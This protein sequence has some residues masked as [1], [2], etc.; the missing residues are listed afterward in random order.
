VYGGGL[1]KVS[2]MALVLSIL[3]WVGCSFLASL[4]GFFLARS[5]MRG[6]REGRLDPSG[7]GQSQVAFWLSAINLC[8]TVLGCGAY[9]LVVVFMGVVLGTAAREVHWQAE[10]QAAMRAEIEAKAYEAIV[11][12]IET[13][14]AGKGAPERAKWKEVR[15]QWDAQRKVKAAGMLANTAATGELLELVTA[16]MRLWT[17]I[18]EGEK[19]VAR[20]NGTVAPF[21]IRSNLPS[22]SGGTDFDD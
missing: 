12:E 11:M 17:L 18:V 14:I 21:R 15:S 7:M 20:E 10:Q 19:K 3:A 22:E 1:P 5:D 9:L 13:A 2:P 16:D 6:I 4:P 8:L